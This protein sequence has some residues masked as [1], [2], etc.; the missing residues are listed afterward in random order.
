LDEI[1]FRENESFFSGV[2]EID[3]AYAADADGDGRVDVV[4]NRPDLGNP[5]QEDA[6]GDEVGDAC[7]NCIPVSNPEQGPAAFEQTVVASDTATFT[8]P[9]P[10]DVMVLRGGLAGISA[11][12][13]DWTDTLAGAEQLVDGQTPAGGSGWYYLLRPSCPAGSWQSEVGAEPGRDATLP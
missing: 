10:A 4:D 3:M 9:E 8:W 6:D 13:V 1:I 5:G 11:Y 2:W 12:P 7:D